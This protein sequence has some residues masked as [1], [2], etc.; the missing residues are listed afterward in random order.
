MAGTGV[1]HGVGILGYSSPG[2]VVS[3]PCK[4]TL[5]VRLDSTV[6]VEGQL[7]YDQVHGQAWERSNF[8]CGNDHLDG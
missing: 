7:V 5:E 4:A 3:E 1:G 8:G 6:Q 2:V